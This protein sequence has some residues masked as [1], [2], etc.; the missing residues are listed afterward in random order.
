MSLDRPALLARFQ[1]AR[2]RTR[3]LFDLLDERAYYQR[4]IALRNPIVFYEGHLPAF[5]VNTLIRRG[6]GRPG[7]DAHLETIFARGIDPEHVA[8]SAG[9]SPWPPREEI[10]AFVNEADR[11][12]LDALHTAPIDQPGHPLLD[13][14]EAVYAIL[15]HEAMHQETLL[16]MLHQLPFSQKRAPANASTPIFCSAGSSTCNRATTPSTRRRSRTT[17]SVWT[18]TA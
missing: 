14:S 4:P 11:R 18:T 16:Y 13:R 15:E 8:V 9:A 10:L 3:A 2:A 1:R 6:L 12:V 7:V 17:A 5:A